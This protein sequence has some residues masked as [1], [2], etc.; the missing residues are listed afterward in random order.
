MF[1][2]SMCFDSSQE[3]VNMNMYEEFT[4]F[5]SFTVFKSKELLKDS[6]D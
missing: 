4:S 1:I 5:L 6:K 3:H 2:I